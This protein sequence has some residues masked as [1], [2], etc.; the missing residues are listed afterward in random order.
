[1]TAYAD[2]TTE[3]REAH[4][5]AVKAWRAK[6]PEKIAA[7]AE[8]LQA[9]RVASSYYQ[10]WRAK[11]P[12]KIAA[13]D[14][15][16]PPRDPAY[17]KQWLDKNRERNNA[18]ARKYRAKNKEKVAAWTKAKA[19]RDPVKYLL[20]SA[21]S[22]ALKQGW[23]FE[24]TASDISIPVVCPVLGIR[25]ERCKSKKAGCSP[26]IDRIDSERGYVP[27]NVAVISLRANRIK[28]DGTIHEHEQ[29]VA[30]MKARLGGYFE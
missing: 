2:M 26:S 25:L 7:Y 23:A 13:A 14:A 24:L 4:N 19:E 17:F 5:K 28:N 3:Q 6:N 16:R 27:G 30:W 8:R 20:K 21:K 1:M 11:N 29:V 18:S 10:E 15:R 9:E 12:E 22:R